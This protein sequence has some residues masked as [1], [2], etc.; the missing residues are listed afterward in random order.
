MRF[1]AATILGFA[2]MVGTADAGS[3]TNRCTPV[4]TVVSN[5]VSAQ[6]VRALVAV[7]PVKSVFDRVR[8]VRPLQ[9]MLNRI[10]QCC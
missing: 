8:A 4:R 5:V 6:P 2:L 9:R 1:I 7:R 10:R 3:C